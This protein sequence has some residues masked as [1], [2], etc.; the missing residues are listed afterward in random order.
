[1]GQGKDNSVKSFIGQKSS[2]ND[3]LMGSFANSYPENHPQESVGVP[4]LPR[5]HAVL[6]RWVI[7]LVKSS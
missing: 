6:C 7:I 2:L 3:P 4:L 1:M 5:E